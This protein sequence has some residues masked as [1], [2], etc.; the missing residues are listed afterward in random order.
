MTTYEV[1]CTFDGAG[2]PTPGNAIDRMLNT[3]ST[4]RDEG[5]EIYHRDTTI[6][7]NEDG[8]NRMMISRFTAPTEGIVGWHVFRARIPV[9][10]IN[11]VDD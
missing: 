5:V 8:S 3:T 6:N 7:S 11:R 10:G 9:C 4:M 2:S 1:T